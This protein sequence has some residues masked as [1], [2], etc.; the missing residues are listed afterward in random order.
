VVKVFAF[1]K[2]EQNRAFFNCLDPMESLPAGCSVGRRK[3]I[4]RIAIKGLRG[5]LGSSSRFDYPAEGYRSCCRPKL[6]A[7]AT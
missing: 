6:A 4:L 7:K 1:L 3:D 2:P 5:Y